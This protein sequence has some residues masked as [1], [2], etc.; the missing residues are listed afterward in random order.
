MLTLPR[1]QLW[2][3]WEV[4]LALGVSISAVSIVRH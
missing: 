4:R 2:K 3:L 1:Y